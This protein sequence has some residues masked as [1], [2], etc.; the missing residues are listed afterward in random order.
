MVPVTAWGDRAKLKVRKTTASA[1][2]FFPVLLHGQGGSHPAQA[3]GL[4]PG[5][6]GKDIE[7]EPLSSS[8]GE[9]CRINC[10]TVLMATCFCYQKNGFTH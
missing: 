9:G 8:L 7:T 6:Q 1:V 3:I 10:S 2:S 5:A 4:Q